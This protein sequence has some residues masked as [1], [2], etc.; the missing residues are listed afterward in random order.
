M[1]GR[2]EK[3][4]T[5]RFKL[6]LVGGFSKSKADIP[7]ETTLALDDTDA[8]DYHYDYS[9]MKYP[10]LSFGAGIDDPAAFELAEFRDRPSF[11]TNK[12]KTFAANLDWAVPDRF[13]LLGG[14]FYTHVDFD[15]IGYCTASPI[16]ADLTT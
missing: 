16:S 9:N 4:L 6:N 8:T 12:F 3:L 10:L 5:D 1:S 7:V 13:K 15:T 2:L 11:L 14:G